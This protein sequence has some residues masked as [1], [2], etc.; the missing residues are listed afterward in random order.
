MERSQ[1]QAELGLR[2]AYG[3]E[4]AQRTIA[5]FS[6]AE[7]SQNPLVRLTIDGEHDIA[8]AGVRIGA[9][10]AGPVTSSITWS[11]MGTT[12]ALAMLPWMHRRAQ[13][14]TVTVGDRTLEGRVELIV[15][16][17]MFPTREKT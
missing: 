7:S 13:A 4:E 2:I 17:A 9:E 8:G 1:Q 12:F 16:E 5:R 3:A 6:R 11:G 15:D 14:A 10:E